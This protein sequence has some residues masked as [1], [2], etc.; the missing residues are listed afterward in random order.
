MVALM[1]RLIA[2]LTRGPEVSSMMRVLEYASM[3]RGP[4]VA[5]MIRDAS[6][7]RGS[8]VAVIRRGP[9]TSLLTSQLTSLSV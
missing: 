2:L 4:E 8:E 7:T 3:T 5:P 6:M 1:T 9:E